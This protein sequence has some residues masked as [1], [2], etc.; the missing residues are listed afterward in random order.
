MGGE[1]GFDDTNIT[2]G[3][4]NTAADLGGCDNIGLL[5]RYLRWWVVL[6]LGGCERL[7]CISAET[8]WLT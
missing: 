8:V 1:G 3:R 6:C 5:V 7:Y 4:R 2:Q